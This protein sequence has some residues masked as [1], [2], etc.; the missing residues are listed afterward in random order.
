MVLLSSLVSCNVDSKTLLGTWYSEEGYCIKFNDDGTYIESY[1]GISLPY[2]L[3]GTTLVYYWIDGYP[4]AVEIDKLTKTSLNVKM[5]SES[6]SFKHSDSEPFVRTWEEAEILEDN[7]HIGCYTLLSDMGEEAQINLFDNYY[8]SFV[9]GD[10]DSIRKASDNVVLGAYTPSPFTDKIEVFTKIEDDTEGCRIASSTLRKFGNDNY[11]ASQKL[12]KSFCKIYKNSSVETTDITYQLDG[13]YRDTANGVTYTFKSDRSLIKSTDD[14]ISLSYVYFVDNDGLVT[15]ACYDGTIEND[16][17]F[18]DIVTG[19]LYRA[20]YQ[21]ETWSDFVQNLNSNPDYIA[22][23]AKCFTVHNQSGIVDNSVCYD[24]GLDDNLVSGISAVEDK[25][26]S[27]DKYNLLDEMS[28]VQE[29]SAE[30]QQQITSQK[31]KEEREQA[32]REERI[33]ELEEIAR[34]RK[35]E[36]FK[37]QEELNQL[38]GASSAYG[39]YEPG[40]GYYEFTG[41]SSDEYILHRDTEFAITTPLIPETPSVTPTPMPSLPTGSEIVRPD[42]D[43]KSI[44]MYIEFYCNCVSCRSSNDIVPENATDVVLADPTILTPGDYIIVNL[45]EEVKTVKVLDS[46]GLVTGNVLMYYSTDHEWFLSQKNGQFEI[47]QAVG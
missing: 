27:K 42:L 44:K 23:I 14:G 29:Q 32:E 34:Q 30:L 19:D 11:L 38:Y 1:F 13:E 31:M 22:P 17:F 36:E 8:L 33:A 20:V 10:T 18:L 43:G 5:G 39:F 24:T 15:A 47:T 40:V 28:I 12:N 41:N 21:R 3:I 26:S 37:K 4:R 45:D 7:S 25:L 2:E 35:E 9:H 16:Y 46:K 6:F